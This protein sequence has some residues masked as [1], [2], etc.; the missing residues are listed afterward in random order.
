MPNTRLL[1]TGATG[2]LGKRALEILKAD[3]DVVGLSKSASSPGIYKLDLRD[4]NGF[5]KLEIDDFDA[6]VH[7]AAAIN[8]DST[9]K[10]IRELFDTNVTGLISLLKFCRDKGARHMVFCSSVSVYGGFERKRL[11]ERSARMPE[12]YYGMSKLLAEEIIRD[13]CEA[14]GLTFSILRFSSIYGPGQRTGNVIHAFIR[15]ALTEKKIRIFGEGTRTQD[16]IYVDDAVQAIALT[17]KKKA[18]IVCNIGSG[19]K[20]T[21][22]RLAG[23]VNKIFIDGCGDIVHYYDREEDNNRYRF[24]VSKA[25]EELGF[26]PRY[27]LAKG[28]GMLK[29]LGK[30]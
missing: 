22:N 8:S 12:S 14:E 11:D 29:T 24:D 2:F 27:T 10:G 6:V 26:K 15:Q 7:T 25:A 16:F 4:A 18:D 1:L 21:M 5:D 3:Y 9:A 30:L 17:L 13:F 23:L 20:T 19:E 28:L